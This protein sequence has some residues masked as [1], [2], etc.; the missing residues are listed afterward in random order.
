[1]KNKP[2]VGIIALILGMLTALIPKVIFP[3]CTNMIELIN[4]KGGIS[5]W[6]FHYK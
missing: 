6:N 2:T 5:I 4:G 1:M 3:V